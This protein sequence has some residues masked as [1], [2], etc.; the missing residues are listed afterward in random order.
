MIGMASVNLAEFAP[1]A[2]QKE[3]EIDVPLLP[4]GIPTESQPTLYVRYSLLI[5]L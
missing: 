2:E 5:L 3:M 1:T 4:M